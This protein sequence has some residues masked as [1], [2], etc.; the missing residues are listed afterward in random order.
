MNLEA[1]HVAKV[2]RGKAELTK[3]TTTALGLLTSDAIEEQWKKSKIKLDEYENVT[4]KK[5]KVVKYDGARP[6]HFDPIA[7][8]TPSHFP[9]NIFYRMQTYCMGCRHLTY[10][11][12]AHYW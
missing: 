11:M 8:Q 4:R 5:G 7:A 6:L 1:A 12:D 2:V 10:L 3:E 9:A